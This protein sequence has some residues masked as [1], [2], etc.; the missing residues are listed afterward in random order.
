[1]Y[2]GCTCTSLWKKTLFKAG[3]EIFDLITLLFTIWK[4][5]TCCLGF[6]FHYS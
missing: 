5:Q 1:M 6:G 3:L 2:G 4:M